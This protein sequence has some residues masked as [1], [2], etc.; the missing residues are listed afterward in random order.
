MSVTAAFV[1]HEVR[2]QARSLRF[3]VLAVLYVLAGSGPAALAYARRSER[4]L[5][6]GSASYAMEILEI[7]PLLTAVVAFLI[8]LDAISRERDE[9]A[10]STVSL[11]GISSAG[12]LL[13]R[14]LA[15]QAVLLPLT[16]LPVLAAAVAAAAGNGLEGLPAGPFLGPWLM[17][18]VPIA[19]AIS[20]LGV[21]LGTIAGGAMSSF[22]L[23]AV[24]LIVVPMLL[25]AAVGRFGLRLTSPLAWL[26]VRSLTGST[27]R[28]I[29]LDAPDRPWGP[30]FP[31]E[32]TAT[33]YDPWVSADQYLAAAALPLA[34]CA[35]TLGFAV[36]YLRRTR[37]DVRPWR[38]PPGHPLRTFL[39]MVSR[40]RERYTPD[41]RPSRADLLAMGLILLAAAGFAALIV[42]RGVR[43]Q[44]LG[45]QRFAVEKSE[46]PAPTP[47]DVT[48]RRWRVEG[49]LGPGRKVSIA[50]AAEMV[51]QG[52]EP[53]SHLAFELNPSLRI[54]EA[55]S[56][57]GGLRLSR[58]WDRLAVDLDRP[59]P[60]G[61]SRE[62]RFRLAGA[63]EETWFSLRFPFYGFHKG[64]GEHLHARF[65]R[66]LEDLSRSH[67]IPAISASRISLE[68]SDLF[69]IPR[70]EPWK[71]VK[72][73]EL[74][75][76]V[77]AEETFRPQGDV[78][79]ALTVPRGVFL[80][81]ACGGTARAGRLTSRCR[82]PLADF[83]VAGGP[84]RPLEAPA[85]GATVAVFP[86][87]QALGEIHLGFLARGT[88]RLEE[89]WPGLGGLRRIVVLEWPERDIHQIGALRGAL[90]RQWY[91]ENSPPVEVRGNL[92][93]L[94]EWLLLRSEPIKPDSLMAELVAGRLERRRA[95][96]SRDS[97]LF[98]R[99][100][101]ELALQRL[102][103]GS[104]NGA[105]VAG[106]RPGMEA[107]VR[108]PPPEG[109]YAPNYWGV[110][111]PAL[112][113]A[114]RY[115]MGEETLRLAL[116]GLLS[117]QGT[118]AL[119]REE[120]YA[121]LVEKDERGEAGQMIQDFFVQGAL[122]EVLL[123][124]V[125][126]R[127]A[128]DGWRVTGRMLNRGT[129]EALCKVVLTTNL[130]PVET[131]ARAEGGQAGGFSFSTSHQ[132]QAVL[133]DPDRE[134][135]RLAVN[136]GDRVFFQG[137]T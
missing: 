1:A 77:V 27:Q 105:V 47:A 9:G 107:M 74:N 36:C 21:G 3:R 136:A 14:W 102:G 15:L 100:F 131:F 111:F 132:P 32:V 113:A 73:P 35:G 103:L 108:V 93:L 37:P 71:L 16:A 86:P 134:C 106:L 67:Q 78:S 96:A 123:E 119:T 80:A 40:T 137:G 88:F 26:Q 64:F 61:G 22:L 41:S 24:V 110:R 130:G 72:D 125:D 79:L 23:G 25:N 6:L 84:H 129:G 19:M 97:S 52:R 98:H 118:A 48:P 49:T 54:E 127:R 34:L 85:G 56:S 33:P 39:A 11:T 82:L 46:S 124:G 90:S 30:T 89:A 63:P 31:M 29:S 55:R 57:A 4:T 18:V 101:R 92:L 28:V 91:W 51:N 109:P 114:L 65:Q 12:Y 45:R 38:I 20:A 99:L 59:I 112:V 7:L 60:P 122:P 68:A 120:L 117:R 8:S 115:R 69:P 104:A 121:L 87:H 126:F 83:L 58:Q 135:H 42:A 133:L 13:R 44:E 50:L 94:R 76:I 5:A 2:T 70:Y 62:I 75:R 95:L 116:D 10:W 53:R 81:D 66:D 17:H 43:Y 128:G